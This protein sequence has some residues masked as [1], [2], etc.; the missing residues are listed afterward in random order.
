[1]RQAVIHHLVPVIF[2]NRFADIGGLM[3]DLRYVVRTEDLT[4]IGGLPVVTL[5]APLKTFLPPDDFIE[6]ITQ[7]SGIPAFQEIIDLEALDSLLDPLRESIKG[8]IS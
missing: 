3:E 6:Q 4:E 7:L 5:E 1:M 2:F 8:L